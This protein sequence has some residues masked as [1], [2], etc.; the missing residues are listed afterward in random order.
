MSVLVVAALLGLCLLALAACSLPTE[1]EPAEPVSI[2]MLLSGVPVTRQASVGMLPGDSLRFDARL[3]D[4]G[5]RTLSSLR[6]TVSSRN[7]AAISLDA[8]GTIR[9]VGR[10]ASW[11][12]AGYNSATR[13]LIAD[14]LQV[15]VVCTTE[16]RAG[17]SLSVTDSITGRLGDVRALSIVART[18]AIRDS[19]FIPVVPAGTLMHNQ[20]LA[21]ARPGTWDITITADG[22]RTWNRGGI[23][24]TTDLCHVITVPITARLVRS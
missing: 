15:S 6:P 4:A 19:I 7:P 3:R 1:S 16:L 11:L 20:L 24:V 5:G 8:G 9:V 23:V 2:Q 22:Y 12:V 17:I 18:A 13:G 21:L 10:G 14:S